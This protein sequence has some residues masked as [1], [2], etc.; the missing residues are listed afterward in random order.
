MKKLYISTVAASLLTTGALADSSSIKDAFAN[1]KVSG[2]ISIY[3]ESTDLNNGNE[4]TGFT[5]SSIGIQ[6]ET[7]SFNGFKIAVGGRTNHN[8]AERNE[9][10]YSDGTDPEAVLS[11]A[12][13]SYTHELG[14]IKVGRQE[15]DLEWISDYHEA[16]VGAITAIPDTTIV[17]GHTTRFMAVDAD[18]PLENIQHIRDTSGV[19]SNNGASVIDVKYE[20]I[21]NTVI[22]PYY[23]DANDVFSAYGLKATTSIENI[24][25][26]AHYAA[27]SED[28]LREDGSIAHI[29]IGTT[30]SNISLAAGYITTDKDGGTG[31]ITH[32]GE[33]ID[34]TE[35]IGDF[36][37]GTNA[38]TFYGSIS[39]EIDMF[40]VGAQYAQVE[41]DTATSTNDK[42][43]EILLTAGVDITEELSFEALYSSVDAENNVE[44]TDKVLAM[45]TYSF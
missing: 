11:T 17:L 42:V 5:N 34:P 7:D 44:D 10:D 9:G 25:L 8:F 43:S 24:D 30:I 2:D 16:V 27:T 37:Y 15:I 29:E 23:M 13:I 21:A 39:A 36:V 14:S 19:D 18:A 40:N 26:T 3:T 33:N 32:L 45:L 1:G 4:D 20:G 38:D 28:V 12:N 22:N 41:Y 6:Y 31:N 35:D